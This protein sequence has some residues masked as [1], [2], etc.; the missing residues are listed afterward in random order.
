ML[1]DVSDEIAA[2]EAAAAGDEQTHARG[3]S[4]REG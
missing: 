3:F 1:E 2:D 4:R